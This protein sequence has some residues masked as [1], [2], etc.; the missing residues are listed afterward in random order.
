[1]GCWRSSHLRLN[2]VLPRPWGGGSGPRRKERRVHHATKDC[3]PDGLGRPHGQLLKEEAECWKP[4]RSPLIPVRS[5]A[6]KLSSWI[7]T[8]SLLCWANVSFIRAVAPPPMS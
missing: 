3:R 2:R 5:A 6:P 8:H 7:R 1:D 4:R